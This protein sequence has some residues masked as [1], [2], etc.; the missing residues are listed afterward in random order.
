MRTDHGADAGPA[1]GDVPL[2]PRSRLPAVRRVLVDLARVLV[3]EQCPGCGA[4]DV[5][6]CPA[7]RSHLA[8]PVRRVEAGAARLDDVRHGPLPTW[9][10]A[11]YTGPVRATVVAWKDRGRGDLGPVLGG[12][13]GRLASEVAPTL[14]DATG[15]AELLVVPVPSSASARRRRGADL[16]A[17]LADAAAA[18]LRGG[19][20]AARAERALAHHRRGVRDQVGLGA[21]ARGRNTAGTFRLRRPDRAP[22]GRWCLLVDD[23]LTT[24]STLAACARVLTGAGGLV[25]GALVLAATPPPGQPGTR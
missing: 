24:G 21:R 16:V 3:P 19:G 14:R 9:A 10:A 18:G 4:W 1:G 5:A 2:D 11:A 25:A 17:D 8:G 13:V 15:G 12:V 20:Q 23:V 7:C 22:Q 6:L